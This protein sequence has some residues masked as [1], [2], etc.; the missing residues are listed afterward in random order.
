MKLIR[1]RDVDSERRAAYPDAGDQFDAIM[2][3]MVA[4]QDQ[5]YVLPPETVTWIEE[6]Q[7]VKEEFPK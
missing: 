7:A 4:L 6:C 5:G 3:G 1:K 2:K